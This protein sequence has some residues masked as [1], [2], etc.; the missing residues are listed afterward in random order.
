[1]SD[2]PFQCPICAYCGDTKKALGIHLAKS[3]PGVNLDLDRHLN[4]RRLESSLITVRDEVTSKKGSKICVFTCPHCGFQT[5]QPNAF[6]L[7]LS[8]EHSLDP[9]QEYLR[10]FHDGVWP[11]CQ[12][13]PS[14]DTRLTWY[15]W[16]TGFPNKIVKGHNYS[17]SMHTDVGKQAAKDG[18]EKARL[19]GWRSWNAGLTKASD[20]RVERYSSKIAEGLARFYSVN[21]SWQ[22]G[23]TADTS[24]GVARARDARCSRL[25]SGEISVWNKGL[26]KETD[27]RLAKI[28]RK[29]KA[30]RLA[31]FDPRRL[32]PAE[33]RQ[34]FNESEQF[35]FT[36]DE[37]RYKNKYTR[38]SVKCRHCGADSEKSVIQI[39]S[40]PNYCSVC[41]PK[42]SK[43]QLEVFDFVKSIC[44]DAVSEDKTLIA[45]K[46]LDIYVPSR[47]V[48]VEYNGLYFHSEVCLERDSEY[49]WNKSRLASEKGIRLIHVFEDEWRD[50]PEVVKSMLR[51]ALGATSRRIAA[52]KCEVKSIAWS[53]AF[54]FLRQNHLDGAGRPAQAWGLFYREQLVACLTLKPSKVDKWQDAVELVR[55]ACTLETSVQGALSKMLSAARP[56][57]LEQGKSK[58][59]TYVDLRYGVGIGYDTV[60]FRDAGRTSLCRYW[61]TDFSRRFD[62]FEFRAAQ[63]DKLSEEDIAV[64]AG[65]ARIYGCPNRVLVKDL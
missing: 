14:C 20:E 28:S 12:H 54:Q 50:R 49:H 40:N 48:A 33:V 53:E 57:I 38:F 52:R 34:R 35:D 44:P 61:Y 4:L 36:D 31:G 24:E 64:A 30:S 56:H 1:M 9:I 10:I 51:H 18:Q 39:V 13:D 60:G 37:S 26:S 7:H 58:I 19:E 16:K 59:M 22:K 55:F 42:A 21:D 32:S 63:E 45:P 11:T 15:G 43:G 5:K 65:V 29:I 46:E 23:L 17:T 25:A 3:H 41:A 8:V 2:V 27:A 62:R 47:K 6:E